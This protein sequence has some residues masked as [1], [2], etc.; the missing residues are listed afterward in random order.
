MKR[1]VPSLAKAY[2]TEMALDLG[3]APGFDPEKQRKI[4]RGTHPYGR[5]PAFPREP[6]GGSYPPDP[7]HPRPGG[8]IRNYAELVASDQYRQIA[9]KVSQALG[10][11]IQQVSV[12]NGMA[13]MTAMMQAFVSVKRFE[14]AHIPELEQMAVNLVLDFPEFEGVRQLVESGHLKLKAHLVEQVDPGDM[15]NQP[16]EPDEEEQ[17][18]LGVAEIAQELDVEKEKRRFVNMLI[19]GA[20]I[21][22]NHAYHLVADRLN[23]LNPRLLPSYAVLMSVADWMYWAIP[24]E[25]LGAM[26]GQGEDAAGVARFYIDEDGVPVIDAQA[27]VFPVLIQEI[28]KGMWEFVTWR[29]QQ[30]E[31]ADPDTQAHV[32]GQVDTLQNE[33]WDIMMGAPVWRQILRIVGGDNQKYLRFVYHELMRLPTQEWHRIMN[34]ILRGDPE[35]R[36]Y[37]QN[38]IQQIKAEQEGGEEEPPAPEGGGEL[39]PAPEGPEGEDAADWWKKESSMDQELNALLRRITG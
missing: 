27:K 3:G 13:I 29:A 25:A 19:Q 28:V 2:F 9:Q 20:A 24:D 22:K 4:E 38:L 26:S 8:R 35:G 23:E 21:N 34:A 31:G 6:G 36:D 5:N 39:P 37:I 17:I 30:E 1:L 33:P 18:E 16:Q 10:I 12:Q 7:Q 11:P 15:Q 14:A 32:Y